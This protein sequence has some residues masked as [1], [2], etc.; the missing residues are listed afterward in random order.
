MY[1]TTLNP[2][3]I[4]LSL[5]ALL[6]VIAHANHLGSITMLSSEKLDNIIISHISSKVTEVPKD[7]HIDLTSFPSDTD[8]LRSHAQTT[9]PREDDDNDQKHYK[10]SV[11]NVSNNNRLLITT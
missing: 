4:S 9:R 5:L 2:T 6:G 10:Q 11:E 1:K 3:I 7:T 8:S